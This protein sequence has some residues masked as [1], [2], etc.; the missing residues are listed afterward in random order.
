MAFRRA[1]SENGIGHTLEIVRDGQACLDYLARR[2]AY[3]GAGQAPR[4]SVIVLNDRLPRLGGQSVLVALQ[5]DPA[6]ALIPVVVFTSSESERKELDSY[7]HCAN[8][9]V[10]K[11]MTYKDL[12]Q[13]VR[14]MVRF[15]EM[16]E[17]PE[18]RS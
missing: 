3:Q 12:S 8:A 2:G 7:A 6:W 14:R 15:W 11:P 4:P 16:V 17:I 5:A 1:W 10:L 9:Y 18:P 13:F